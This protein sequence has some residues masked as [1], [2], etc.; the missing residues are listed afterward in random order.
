MNVRQPMDVS[1]LF[2]I[3]NISFDKMD[4]RLF[5]FSCDEIELHGIANFIRKNFIALKQ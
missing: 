1:D 4:L 5:L 3:K 2:S